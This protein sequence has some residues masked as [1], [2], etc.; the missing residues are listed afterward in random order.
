[1][2]TSN[3]KGRVLRN[4]IANYEHIQLRNLYILNLYHDKN[5][6]DELF[7]SSFL[8]EE[9]NERDSDWREM[10]ILTAEANSMLF[11]PL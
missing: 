8:K 11:V 2:E 10:I 5:V 3:N 6:E 7:A 1:M 4:R 9:R